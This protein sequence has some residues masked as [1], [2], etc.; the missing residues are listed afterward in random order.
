LEEFQQTN[1]KLKIDAGM[2]VPTKSP[3][4]GSS[5]DSGERILDNSP[6]EYAQTKQPI[7][8]PLVEVPSTPPSPTIQ[9]SPVTTAPNY[10]T[11]GQTN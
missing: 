1:P 8:S 2:P 10:S 5:I 11:E 6:K 9:N 3:S 7:V 4:T